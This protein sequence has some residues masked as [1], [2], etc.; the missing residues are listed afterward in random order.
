MCQLIPNSNKTMMLVGIVFQVIDCDNWY[1]LFCWIPRSFE[2]SQT[3]KQLLTTNTL[4]SPQNPKSAGR[5]TESSHF[6]RQRTEWEDVV[7]P[8]FLSRY[9]KT[10]F[11]VR[12]W[13]SH[14]FKTCAPS[15][16]GKFV[17]SCKKTWLLLTI[18]L[19]LCLLQVWN[20][21]QSGH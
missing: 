17:V 20:F 1:L 6:S 7:Q 19:F 14:Q 12:M 13:F 21:N 4:A 15:S 18:S 3:Y 10:L 16:Y 2:Q 5:T 9:V 8:P 11:N